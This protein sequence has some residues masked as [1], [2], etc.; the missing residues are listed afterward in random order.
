MTAYELYDALDKA[1]IDFE[2]VEIEDGLR[3]ISIMVDE[4]SDDDLEE[5][6]TDEKI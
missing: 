4:V 5:G 6:M 3:V 2:I 1:D